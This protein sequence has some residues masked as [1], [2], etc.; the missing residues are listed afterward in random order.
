MNAESI[1]ES[2]TEDDEIPGQM[3]ITKDMPEYCPEFMNEPEE[4]GQN[5]IAPAQIATENT[6]READFQEVEDPEK[7]VRP[8]G[9]RKAYLDKQTEYTA[10]LYITAFIKDLRNKTFTELTDAGRWEKW[11]KEEVDDHGEEIDI[12]E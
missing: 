2:M 8:Y 4:T 6:E 11:L 5:Q 1:P 12:V 10:A 7:M 3:E 9:T